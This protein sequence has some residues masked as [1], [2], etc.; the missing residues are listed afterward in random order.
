MYLV[1]LF[2]F[3]FKSKDMNKAGSGD[4][5]CLLNTLSFPLFEYHFLLKIQV[6]IIKIIKRVEAHTFH[7]RTI[8]IVVVTFW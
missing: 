5:F 4:T 1:W 3:Y 6:R 8:N 2:F 7:Y